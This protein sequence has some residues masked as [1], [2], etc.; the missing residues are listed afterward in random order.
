MKVFFI[1]FFCFVVPFVTGA[2]FCLWT[3][4]RSAAVMLVMLLKPVD[5]AEP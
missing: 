3:G 5:E 4:V 1:F 2:S